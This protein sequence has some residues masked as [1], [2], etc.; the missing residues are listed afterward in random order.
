MGKGKKDKKK[1]QKDSRARAQEKAAK[2]AAKVSE[3]REEVSEDG[4]AARRL[5]RRPPCRQGLLAR[6]RRHARRRRLRR[7]RGG[8]QGGARGGPGRAVRPAWSGSSPS[9]TAGSK[10]SL[11]LVVQGM[12]TSGKGGLMR[13]VIS[14]N[15]EGVGPR[16]SRSRRQEE[17]AHDFLWRVEK[18]LPRPGPARSLRPLPLRGRPRRA[19]ARPRAARGV[20]EALRADQRLRAAR[21]IARAPRSSR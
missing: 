20:V 3:A 16:P 14:V 15:P 10:R 19:G 4:R 17:L 5:R 21:S 12:D 1:K 13:H 8:R 11:L 7:R 6:R 9:P 18:A 2:K